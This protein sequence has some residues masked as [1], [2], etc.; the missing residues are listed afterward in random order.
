VL[1]IAP[2][3]RAVAAGRDAAPDAAIA[4]VSGVVLLILSVWLLVEA[5]RILSRR[6]AA[7]AA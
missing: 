1:Q 6:A 2:W 7:G 4:G 3:A 5:V